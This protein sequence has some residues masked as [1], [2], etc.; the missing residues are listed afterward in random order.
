METK[1]SFSDLLSEKRRNRKIVAVSCYD[2]TTAKLISHTNVQMVL[3]GDSAAQAM[4]GYDS[5]LPATMDFMVAITAAVRRGAP[6]VYLVADMP[7]LSYQV[8]KSEAVRNAGRFVVEAG[9][10]MIKIEAS[11]AYLDT[12]KAVSDANMAVMAHIGIR[13]Q[14]ISK[15]GRLKA[16]ATT[17]DMALELVALAD[18]MIQAGAS[19]LLIEGTAAEVADI[20]TKHCELPVISCGSGPG[21]DGQILIAPD[22]LGLTT[23]T[24]PKF[25]KSYGNL[26][27]D[28]IEA[29]NQ[30]CTDVL[31][32][33]FP[34]K[35]H[36][37]HMKAGE[38]DK[39]QEL[40]KD[41]L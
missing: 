8:G 4:L 31:S 25:A 32:G 37:Y 34:D 26:A 9:A 5:T 30:Y 22:I 15:V 17:A 24:G 23:E 35:E 11:G 38:L 19:S 3:V 6:N 29:F 39:L 1:I 2:Y 40:L 28:T 21:C 18:Q 13:P 7:F 27:H 12:I 33:Q 20:I 36:S 16:E 14:T 41:T 10:Q